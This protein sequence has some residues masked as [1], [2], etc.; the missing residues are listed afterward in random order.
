MTGSKGMCIAA[1]SLAADR[2]PSRKKQVELLEWIMCAFWSFLFQILELFF[3]RIMLI[4][5]G[6]LQGQN[7]GWVT[8]MKVAPCHPLSTSSPV[9]SHF[10][11]WVTGSTTLSAPKETLMVDEEDATWEASL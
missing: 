11:T 6:S 3:C 5:S 1:Y 9:P 7:S 2:L 10:Y 8:L 4:L